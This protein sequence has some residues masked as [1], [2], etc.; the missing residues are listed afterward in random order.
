MYLF[1]VLEI[2]F[3][4]FNVIISLNACD[5]VLVLFFETTIL[6]GICFLA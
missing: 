5:N 3:N 4:Q 6:F 2:I 1:F